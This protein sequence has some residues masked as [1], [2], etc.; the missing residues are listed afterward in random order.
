MYVSDTFSFGSIIGE[1]TNKGSNGYAL[2]PI[3]IDRHGVDSEE[4]RITNS[5]LKQCCKAQSAQIDRTKLG[6]KVKGIPKIWI[7]KDPANDPMYASI[8]LQ[9]KPYFFKYRYRETRK[10]YDNYVEQ[11]KVSCLQRFGVE[12]KDLLRSDCLTPEQQEFI[13]NYYHY[14]PVTYSKSTMN[15]LCEYIESVDFNISSKIKAIE[16]SFDYTI[17]KHRDI[18]YS[19][20][21][22]DAVVGYVRHVMK[23]FSTSAVLNDDNDDER[24]EEKYKDLTLGERIDAEIC[25]YV[26]SR[27]VVANILVDYFYGERPK[28]DKSILWDVC[29]KTIFKNVKRNSDNKIYFP[30][31]DENGSIDYMGGRYELREVEING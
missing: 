11:N 12:L 19:T 2:L 17:Y 22:Y 27:D 24:N 21:E 30:V 6:Q 4:V 9:T 23:V 28:S 16:D 18:A 5:R 29:G 8:L 14:M 13:N 31:N 15:M 20:E 26:A 25:E 3:L 7:K 1:I 10:K